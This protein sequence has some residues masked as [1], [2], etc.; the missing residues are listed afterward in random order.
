M[1][2]VLGLGVCRVTGERVG[3]AA[4]EANGSSLA[5]V[6]FSSEASEGSEVRGGTDGEASRLPLGTAKDPACEL[7]E[8]EAEAACAN[9]TG[10]G[11]KRDG[12]RLRP[13]SDESVSSSAPLAGRGIGLTAD[14]ATS[15]QPGV[16]G[17]GTGSGG[18]PTWLGLASGRDESGTETSRRAVASGGSLTADDELPEGEAGERCSSGGTPARPRSS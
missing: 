8:D 12:A 10:V 16:N 17:V 13:G 18:R 7:A 15:D 2:S 1:S 3:E 9:A 11:G 4:T 5:G 6:L 14:D